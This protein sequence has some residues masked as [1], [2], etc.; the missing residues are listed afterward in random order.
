MY[1]VEVEMVLFFSWYEDG[2]V[3][4]DGV[5]RKKAGKYFFASPCVVCE[6]DRGKNEKKCQFFKFLHI[7]CKVYILI[8]LAAASYNKD[9][10]INDCTF[11]YIFF[12]KLHK[13]IEC[14][15]FLEFN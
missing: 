15:W 12:L 14:C 3:N 5:V 13:S 10:I 6:A 11:L 2:L 8:K 1:F 7:L 4:K 9:T